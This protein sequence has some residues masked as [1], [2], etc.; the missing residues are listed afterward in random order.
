MNKFRAWLG[1]EI[2]PGVN[3]TMIYSANYSS[4]SRFFHSFDCRYGEKK[5]LMRPTNIKDKNG[6]LW[7][8]GDTLKRIGGGGWAVNIFFDGL[9][10]RLKTE[11]GGLGH[12]EA[13]DTSF[14]E[15]IGNIYENPELTEWANKAG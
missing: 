12:L 14:L 2:S 6:N 10:F 5:Y 1:N 13:D 7:W 11:F 15:K 8:E 9:S 4:L 3:E